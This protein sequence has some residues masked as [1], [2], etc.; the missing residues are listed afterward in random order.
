MYFPH[1]WMKTVRNEDEIFQLYFNF[2]TSHLFILSKNFLTIWKV[3][4]KGLHQIL[5]E[6]VSAEQLIWKGFDHFILKVQNSN[7]LQFYSFIKSKLIKLKEIEVED[8]GKITCLSHDQKNLIV[9]TQSGYMILVSWEGNIVQS[10]SL[11]FIK[12]GIPVKELGFHQDYYTII[13][14]DGT[15]AL[16]KESQS[17]KYFLFF[18]F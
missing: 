11:D 9:G 10:V 15:F 6:K 12:K 2:L 8:Y 1:G 16:F 17:V 14:E 5:K 13:L 3:D 18:N 4:Q 7:I